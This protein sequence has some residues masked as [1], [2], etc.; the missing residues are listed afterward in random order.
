[1]YFW[2]NQQLPWEASTHKFRTRI[3][4]SLIRVAVDCLT[5]QTWNSALH[6][7]HLISLL[8]TESKP[9]VKCCKIPIPHHTTP[10]KNSQK[11]RTSNR[12]R[13]ND[14][15]IH[16][17]RS[18][19]NL[20]LHLHY[21]YMQKIFQKQIHSSI[22]DMKDVFMWRMSTILLR[23]PCRLSV[24]NRRICA[25]LFWMEDKFQGI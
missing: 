10:S 23:E 11:V 4:K 7:L 21:K 19:H 2:P 24:E 22:H 16:V 17:W 8:G 18:W 6:Q 15:Y 5:G 9:H 1:M 14:H 20:D 3:N 12:T 25:K 13:G